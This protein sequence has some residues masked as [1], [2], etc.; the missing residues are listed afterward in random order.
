MLLLLTLQKYLMYLEFKI[1][2]YKNKTINTINIFQKGSL[3]QDG[4]LCDGVNELI[5]QSNFVSF[6]F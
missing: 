3:D 4:K 1:I 2:D 5:N 6:N